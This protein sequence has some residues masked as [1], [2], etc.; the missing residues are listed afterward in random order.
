MAYHERSYRIGFGGGLTQIVKYLLIINIA[1]FFLQ[2]LGLDKIFVQLLALNP[3]LA[4]LKFHIWQ[5]LTYMFLHGGVIHIFFNMLF[6]WIFGC[7]VE[8]TLGS[9]EFLKYYL[10]CGVG[11]GIIHQIFNLNSSI[12][13]LGASG[14]IFGVMVA[15]AILFPERVITLLLFFVLPVQLKAKYLVMIFIGIELLFFTSQDGISHFAHL[16]GA[17]IG[18]LY[19]KLDW[20]LDFIGNW[21]R[22]QRDSKHAV[23]KLKRNQAMHEIRERV[24]EILDKI[25]EVG[26]DQLSEA[27][28][29]I[30][31]EASQKYSQEKEPEK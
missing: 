27:E 20:R 3:Q 17:A 23:T 31:Q 21:I 8:R 26:Y 6:L 16:G 4:L 2:S 15:F 14:A 24:D 5:F 1:I 28:K 11:A 19:L 10:V 9:K 7:E 25:N 12:P 18:F 30:L 29:R 13:M 22:Q